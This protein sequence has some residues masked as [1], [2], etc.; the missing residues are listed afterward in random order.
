MQQEKVTLR[1]LNL[2][3]QQVIKTG[4]PE[5]VWVVAEISEIKIHSAGHCYL[6]LVEKSEDEEGPVARARGIIWAFVF[7][8]LKPYFETTTGQVLREG[9]KVLIKATVEFH[10]LYGLSLNIT[11]I[12]PGYTIGDLALRKAET[13]RRLE[14]D[15]VIHMNRELELPPVPQRI[16]V[17]SSEQAAGLQDFLDQLH[18]NPQGY[19]FYTRIFPALMQG[20]EAETSIIRAFDTIFRFE[21]FFDVVVL[22]RG[23]GSQADLACFNN[24]RLAYHIAQFPLPV[25]TGIGHEKDESVA[26][27]VAHTALKTPTAVAEFLVDRVSA[28]DEHLSRQASLVSEGVMAIL[29]S[30]KQRI[31]RITRIFSPLVM[32]ELNRRKHRLSRSVHILQSAA[33]NLLKSNHHSLRDIRSRSAHQFRLLFRTERERTAKLTWQTVH[34]G[35]QFI[36]NAA[37]RLEMFEKTNRLTDPAQI[38]RKG[39]SITYHEDKVVRDSQ[40]LSEGQSIQTRLFRGTV[41]SRVESTDPGGTGNTS[42]DDPQK[43]KTQ[44]KSTTK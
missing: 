38:L 34:S 10:E 35:R 18:H 32:Q 39:F 26:D 41:S 28:F 15:G 31:D 24:Y 21:D 19:V 13:I 27:I 43:D 1:E 14:Q 6:E 5:P 16:A 8:M 9:L 20:R 44:H 25:I 4:L 29:K 2:R 23:G 42:Q 7:R 11:D 40:T 12:D 36:R 30:E 22:I 33:R 17:I 3:I 37:L